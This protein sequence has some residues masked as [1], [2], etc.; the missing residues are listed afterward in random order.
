MAITELFDLFITAMNRYFKEKKSCFYHDAYNIWNQ[1]ENA[2]YRLVFEPHNEE[3]I[4]VM[5]Y[6]N[7]EYITAS[8]IHI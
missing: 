7:K 5:L 2:G 6:K 3:K 1:L 8:Y 4:I